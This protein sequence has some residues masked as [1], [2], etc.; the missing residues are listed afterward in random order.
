[1]QPLLPHHPKVGLLLL[2]PVWRLVLLL[3][4]LLLVPSWC[5][6]RQQLCHPGLM[7]GA[8]LPGLAANCPCGGFERLSLLLPLL[9]L[10][11]GA[12]NH[13]LPITSTSIGRTSSASL[14]GSVRER[15]RSSLGQLLQQTG[16]EGRDVACTC[17]HLVLLLGCGCLGVAA[18]AAAAGCCCWR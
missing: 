18:N 14:N 5:Q 10:L 12:A 16:L 11:V 7:L 2:P 17:N 3:L 4:L 13:I 8:D 1:L 9:P 6:V 15:T